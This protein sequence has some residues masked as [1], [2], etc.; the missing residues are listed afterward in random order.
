MRKETVSLN[1]KEQ[2]PLMVL[3]WVERGDLTGKQAATLV[4]L[5]LRQVR[6]LRAAYRKE[7]AAALAQGNRGRCPG[8]AFSEETKEA[9]SS[10]GS[11]PLCWLQSSPP[12]GASGRAGGLG[13]ESFIGLAHSHCCGVEK[14]ATAPTTPASLP[15]GTLPPGRDA[16]AGGWQ[17]P[18]LAGRSGALPHPGR[19]C[20]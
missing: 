4:S 14:P 12:D 5:S 10:P 9:S 1:Q 2:Q 3:N 20:G 11:R 15:A 7:G 6:R 8:H 17:P 13:A 19:D 16:V 18:R